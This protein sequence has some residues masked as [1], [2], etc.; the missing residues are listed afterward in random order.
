ML[1]MVYSVNKHPPF[2]IPQV[3]Q[4]VLMVY[5]IG[6]VQNVNKTINYIAM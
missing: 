4:K 3:Q 2:K 5:E 1:K 6:L